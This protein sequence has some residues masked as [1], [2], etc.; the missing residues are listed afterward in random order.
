MDKHKTWDHVD[1]MRFNKDKGKVLRMG[2]GNPPVHSSLG[3][4]GLKSSPEK[5]LGHWMV[6]SQIWA[7]TECCQSSLSLS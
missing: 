7:G 5:N 3:E 1:L 4:E 6:K 2:W